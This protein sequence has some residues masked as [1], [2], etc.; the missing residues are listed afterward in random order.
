MT[1][2]DGRA[3]SFRLAEIHGAVVLFG[4][5]GLFGKWLALSPMVIVFGRV[6]FAGL[7]LGAVLLLRRRRSKDTPR[8]A[9]SADLWMFLGLGVLL[10]VHW[11]LFFLSVQVSTV[12]VGLLS[13]S[14]F[15]VFTAFLEPAL[16]KKRLEPASLFFSGMCLLGVF[17]IVP[18]F[19][20]TESVFRG[21]V[22]GL[23]AGLT[24]AVL[25][26][27][28]RR[29]TAR[30]D[31]IV[32]A[33]RQD[34]F[35]ALVLFPALFIVRPILSAGDLGL[36]AAL[37]IVC[38]AGAHTLF[39][40]G[41]RAIT[42]QSASVIASLEPVYGI[43]LALAFLGEVPAPRTLLGGAVILAAA[44]AVSLRDF[45]RSGKS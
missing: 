43:I 17:L 33:F 37:G 45:R 20:W 3:R 13:Y 32:I 28:N 4:L 40:D 21:V 16:S 7:V 42:A 15:P 30:H 44:T 6:A 22:L 41:M 25:S 11:T 24:F 34:A 35:A 31:S 5:A 27:L 23:G 9:S 1:A 12:A 8:M 36:L 14:S 38:T 26:V 10:A 18:R 29:L 2:E 19:S 39:I